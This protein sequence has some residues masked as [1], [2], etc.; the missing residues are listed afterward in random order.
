MQVDFDRVIDAFRR[1][2]RAADENLERGQNPYLT[3]DALHKLWDLAWQHCI[4]IH[5]MDTMHTKILRLQKIVT[6]QQQEINAL[7]K[8]AQQMRKSY[9]VDH[10]PVQSVLKAVHDTLYSGYAQAR[11]DEDLDPADDDHI[12]ETFWSFGWRLG[13]EERNFERLKQVCNKAYAEIETLRASNVELDSTVAD[14]RK[15]IQGH[16]QHR[17]LAYAAYGELEA[18]LTAFYDRFG[19]PENERK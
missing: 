10:E 15:T 12:F 5:T 6:D 18:E 8:E 14:L 19:V 2:V 13:T 17:A 1:G 4:E 7:Q 16:E 11:C 9:A 3:N